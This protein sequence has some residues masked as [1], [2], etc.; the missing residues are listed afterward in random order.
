RYTFGMPEN[1][2]QRDQRTH[3]MAEHDDGQARIFLC[4]PLVD[5]QN[6]ADHLVS[7]GL[8]SER[9]GRGIGCPRAAMP[10]MI[11]GVDDEAVFGKISGE[12]LVARG[13]L[14]KA[15]V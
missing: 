5:C 2:V 4:N 1:E 14:G 6:V 11:V 15:V 13:V 10:A 7:C 12:A 8:L 9:T 3:R